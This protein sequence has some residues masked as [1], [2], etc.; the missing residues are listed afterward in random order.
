MNQFA[1]YYKHMIDER[2]QC[3]CSDDSGITSPMVG[4]F[5][6]GS[7]NS[8]DSVKQVVRDYFED[9]FKQLTDLEK[10]IWT[11]CYHHHN[12]NCLNVVRYDELL[13]EHPVLF[14]KTFAEVRDSSVEFLEAKWKSIKEN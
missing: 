3:K 5:S 6:S 7:S 8:S 4:M 2:L 1:E 13:H 10:E 14:M 12:G 9:K 11:L